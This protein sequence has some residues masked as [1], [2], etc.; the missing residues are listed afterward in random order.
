[1]AIYDPK[2]EPSKSEGRAIALLNKLL[3][4]AAGEG[5]ANSGEDLLDISPSEAAEMADFLFEFLRSRKFV[6][7]AFF[8][9]SLAATGP[10][11]N[12]RAK[13]I[14]LSWRT[15]LGK[16]RVASTFAWNEFVVRAGFGFTDNAQ[17]Y[18]RTYR[19][20]V[21]PMPLRHFLAMEVRLARSYGLSKAA[22]GIISD[23][24]AR[25][26]R[27]I[28]ELR[29]GDRDLP[30]GAVQKSATETAESFEAVA[31]CSPKKS[32]SKAR[33]AACTGL[34]MDVGAFF[35]T[36][37]WTATGVASVAGGTFPDLVGVN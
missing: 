2:I 36:R 29:R 24:Y 3:E 30:Q 23:Y 14:Y 18:V 1:V 25:R 4:R 17:M 5:S 37:D 13:E 20:A 9:E 26:L 6:E 22:T 11:S 7:A 34:I 35:I 19:H 8:T 32:I 33:L 21:Q 28:D 10:L 12:D 15:R 31:K 16:T 27:L